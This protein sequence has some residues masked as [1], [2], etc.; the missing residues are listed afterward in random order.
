MFSAR[1]ECVVQII[2]GTMGTT[3]PGWLES[4]RV[5]RHLYCVEWIPSTTVASIKTTC[6]LIG[7]PGQPSTLDALSRTVT[8][9]RL[10]FMLCTEVMHAMP[11]V[12]T[13]LALVQSQ[14]VGRRAE[15][16]L[17]NAA[18]ASIPEWHDGLRG[19]SR[20]VRL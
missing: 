6:I 3:N 12:S 19:L 10:M 14:A 7:R 5:Q 20:S 4:Q 18:S 9:V 8:F 11:V 16:Y 15:L 2:G 1:C 17:V 13:A